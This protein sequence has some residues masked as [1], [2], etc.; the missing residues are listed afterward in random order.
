MKRGYEKAIEA[1]GKVAIQA[2][3]AVV[4]I[5]VVI[6]SKGNVSASSS[7]ATLQ[8]TVGRALAKAAVRGIEAMVEQHHPEHEA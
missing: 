4:A 8:G 6:D 7:D 1:L 3:G 5:V 2:S